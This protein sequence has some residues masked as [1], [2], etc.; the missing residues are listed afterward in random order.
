[1]PN[2][3]LLLIRGLPGAG[4]TTLAHVLADAA[5]APV[6]SVDDY[7]TNPATGEYQFDFAQNH[8]AYRQCESNTRLAMAQGAPLVVVHNVFSLEWEVAPYFALAAEFGYRVHVVTV[9][10]YHGS[11]NTHGVTHDQ[12]LRMAAKYKVKLM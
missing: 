7:F 10:N 3:E 6:F 2:G 12:L 9:E 1:M 11:H 5:D 4:K 8:E